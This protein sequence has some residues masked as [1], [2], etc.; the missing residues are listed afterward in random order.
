M[1]RLAPRITRLSFRNITLRDN[2][3][4]TWSSL[5]DLKC[6]LSGWLWV[7]LDYCPSLTHLTIRRDD[8]SPDFIQG[9][10]YCLLSVVSFSVLNDMIDCY[11]DYDASFADTIGILLD[12]FTF[13]HL[14]TLFLQGESSPNSFRPFRQIS[15]F[16]E[17][18]NCPLTV[19]ALSGHSLTDQELVSILARLPSL[20]ELS[21]ENPPNSDSAICPISTTFVQSLHASKR[22]DIYDS[23]KP[24]LPRLRS[25][26]LRV[27]KIT[28]I[29]LPSWRVCRLGGYPISPPARRMTWS[30]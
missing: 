13:P 27:E 15:E 7:V 24:L 8:A 23:T 3:I 29:L 19:L 12:S 21:L 22:C 28:L 25:S 2:I 11:A 30:A 6:D 4:T 16:L 14:D 18:S 5:T 10:P 20:Q 26:V 9:Y 17:R 1:F